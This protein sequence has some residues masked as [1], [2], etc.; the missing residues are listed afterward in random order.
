MLAGMKPYL[1]R[2]VVLEH[3]LSRLRSAVREASACRA[4]RQP[5]STHGPDRMP[6]SCERC[7]AAEF[8]FS[9][10]LR[11]SAT[12][13]ERARFSDPDDEMQN[14]LVVCSWCRS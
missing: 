14:L 6:A 11:H 9:C 7:G 3:P 1:R 13:K 10:Y 5:W 12:A 2:I 4:C 8:D